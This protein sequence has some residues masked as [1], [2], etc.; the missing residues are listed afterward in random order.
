MCNH[1]QRFT[2]C[3]WRPY[4][5]P[6]LNRQQRA[7]RLHWVMLQRLSFLNLPHAHLRRSNAAHTVPWPAQSPSCTQMSIGEGPHCLPVKFTWPTYSHHGEVMPGN[8]GGLE[9]HPTGLNYSSKPIH[10]TEMPRSAWST[11]FVKSVIDLAALNKLLAAKYTNKR[12]FSNWWLS[13]DCWFNPYQ[14]IS[15]GSVHND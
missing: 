9:W 8:P 3:A 6:I 11:Q 15:L 13:T 7:A 1:R 12:L 10:A 14:T 2:L 4:R 5:G